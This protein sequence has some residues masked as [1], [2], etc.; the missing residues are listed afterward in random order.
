MK[1]ELDTFYQDALADYLKDMDADIV[2]VFPGTDPD[3]TV[4]QR[5]KAILESL[6][7]IEDGDYEE[8]DS[9]D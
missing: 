7:R 3:A 9:D 1:L 4:E 6:K 2:Y 5:A 8:Y